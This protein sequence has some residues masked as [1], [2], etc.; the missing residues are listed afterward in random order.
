MSV[1]WDPT[2]LILQKAASALH[3]LGIPGQSRG[4]QAR[5]RRP[6]MRHAGARS[7]AQW[8]VP[9]GEFPAVELKAGEEAHEGPH[10][11]VR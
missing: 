10:P 7:R 8:F 1:W 2:P 11:C 3:H 6:L 9:S 5:Q 4:I